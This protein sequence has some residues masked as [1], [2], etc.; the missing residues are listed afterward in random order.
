MTRPTITVRLALALSAALAYP[1][2][3]AAHHSSAMYDRTRLIA[4]RGVVKE[5]RWTNPRVTLKISVDGTNGKG[6]DL[7]IV[8][9]TS[10]GN[11]SR[12]GWTRTSVGLEQRV[13]VVAAA[14]RDGGHGA[15]CQSVTLL[16]SRKK[17]EC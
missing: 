2:S 15:Y 13:E 4:L 6:G 11:L 8:E 5:F 1:L 7:W 3:A 14:L 16:E 10:P 17:L 12:D 9:A